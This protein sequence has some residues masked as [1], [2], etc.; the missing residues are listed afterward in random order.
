[1]LQ[2]HLRVGRLYSHVTGS[3]PD[4]DL[5]GV[6]SLYPLVP[7]RLFAYTEKASGVSRVDA[8]LRTALSR[9]TNYGAEYRIILPDGSL[10]WIAS[11]GRGEYA[12][13]R[14][15]RMMGVALDVTDRKRAEE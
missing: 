7:D 3:W 8:A 11:T 5:S 2:A 1:R 14:P 13:S 10:R 6:M 12:D 15:V 9:R 4:G